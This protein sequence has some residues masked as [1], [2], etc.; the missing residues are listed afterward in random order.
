MAHYAFLDENNKVVQVIV[1]KDEGNMDWETFYSMEVGLAC[2][3][4]S[5]NTVGGVYYDP[6]TNKPA[7]DQS[8]AFRKNFA[9]VG[10]FYD[11]EKDAFIPPKEFDSWILNEKTCLWE[12]PIPMPIGEEQYTWDEAAQQWISITQ[13]RM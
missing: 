1:G 2:K 12:A 7:T 9:G 6:S 11:Q 5:Y 10:Y 3:R 13:E 8:K 4:T